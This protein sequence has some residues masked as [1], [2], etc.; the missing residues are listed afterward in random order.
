MQLLVYV[1]HVE[2]RFGQ[3]GDNVSFGGRQVHSLRQTNHRLR[4]SFWTHLM[5]VLGDEAQV[6]ARFRP[7]RDSANLDVR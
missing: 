7:F 2:T 4:K 3:F 6:V 5:V 1:R